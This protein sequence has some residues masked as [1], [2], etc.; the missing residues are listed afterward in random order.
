MEFLTN[1][2]M[3]HDARCYPMPR[4]AQECNDA[5]AV[6]CAE[7]AGTKVVDRALSIDMPRKAIGENR[8]GHSPPSFVQSAYYSS[9]TR[10]TRRIENP[11]CG[12]MGLQEL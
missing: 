7:R 8:S 12:G 5:G 2:N 9:S 6:G 10:R 1:S 4:Q 11:V 3:C